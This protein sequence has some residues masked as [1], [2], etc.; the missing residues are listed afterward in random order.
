MESGLIS[1]LVIQL[2]FALA[3]VG[4]LLSWFGRADY[5][6][7]VF[8]AVPVLYFIGAGVSAARRRV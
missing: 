3:A 8:A 5:L 4:I 2:V 6:F 7:W 1:A